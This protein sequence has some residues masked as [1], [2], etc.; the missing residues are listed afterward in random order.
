LLAHG[1]CWC[2]Y[3]AGRRKRRPYKRVI[4]IGNGYGTCVT[5]EARNLS[6]SVRFSINMFVINMLRFFERRQINEKRG[7]RIL[8]LKK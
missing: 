7:M 3:Q 4:F 8:R 1:L 6:E 5:P 2:G